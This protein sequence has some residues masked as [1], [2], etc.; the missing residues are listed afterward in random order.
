MW[1]VLI[2][3]LWPISVYAADFNMSMVFVDKGEILVTNDRWVII[4][5]IKLDDCKYGF[6]RILKFAQNLVGK[7]NEFRAEMEQTD[8]SI[9]IF[10]GTGISRAGVLEY[11]NTI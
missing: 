7:L 6:E 2:A 1:C 8:H 10:H 5:D 3:L 11:S 4:M 9:Y